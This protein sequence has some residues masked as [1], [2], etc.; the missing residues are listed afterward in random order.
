MRAHSPSVGSGVARDACGQ[1]GSQGSRL[2]SLP[3]QGPS[4]VA[5][6]AMMFF[7]LGHED[8]CVAAACVHL[9][10]PWPLHS[11]KPTAPGTT[12]KLGPGSASL[13]NAL[14]ATAHQQSLQTW[15]EQK[16]G[17]GHLLLSP[18]LLSL[19]LISVQKPPLQ[20]HQTTAKKPALLHLPS[21]SL[22]PAIFTEP[23]PTLLLLWTINS[24][25]AALIL[26]PA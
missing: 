25:R 16:E 7:L 10:L 14:H 1:S 5:R 4:S 8:P 22:N 18:V 20:W 26:Y 19:I 12:R 13:I 3:D 24:L 2:T 15:K 23:L 11:S 6:T 21:T 17:S 9:P